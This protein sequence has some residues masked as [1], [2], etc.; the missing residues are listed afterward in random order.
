ML[1]IKYIKKFIAIEI[2]HIFSHIG[3]ASNEAVDAAANLARLR[4]IVNLLI[5]PEYGDIKHHVFAYINKL[6]H[7]Q[8]VEHNKC[9]AF[10]KL[11]RPSLDTSVSIYSTKWKNQVI[12]VRP[13]TGRNLL[14]ASLHTRN[15][16]DSRLCFCG[17]QQTTEHL[18][19]DS[20]CPLYKTQ[21]KRRVFAQN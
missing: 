13:R 16:H 7:Q 15:L 19:L 1:H 5:E 21:L 11:I 2:R 4:P 14:A 8:Y 20:T 18:L 17:K 10:Y 12:N 6:W 3:V 9:G